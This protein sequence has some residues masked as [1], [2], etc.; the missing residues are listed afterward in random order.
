[1]LNFTNKFANKNEQ[2]FYLRGLIE[3][4][5]VQSIRNRNAPE[6]SSKHKSHIYRYYVKADGEKKENY[7]KA[8]IS[9]H[10]VTFKRVCRL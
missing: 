1:V 10:G 4:K 5:P 8:F 9:Q 7:K 3:S 6:K 2:D